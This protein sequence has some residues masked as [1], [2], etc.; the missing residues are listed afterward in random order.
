MIELAGTFVSDLKSRTSGVQT[1]HEH[2]S[3]RC[4]QPQLLL[5]L[6][7]AHGGQRPEMVVQVLVLHRPT[8]RPVRMI[9]IGG[10]VG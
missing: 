2:A 5:I 3:S 4:L 7:R 10:I 9:D 1:I 6:K 8:P